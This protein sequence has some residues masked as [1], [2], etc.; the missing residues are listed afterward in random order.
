MA[1]PVLV[2]EDD[3]DIRQ[4]LLASLEQ[5]GFRV[6]SA[7][8]GEEAIR[9]AT[10]TRPAAVILDVALPKVSGAEVAASIRDL[11]PDGVP[12]LVISA[13]DRIEDVRTRIRAERYLAKPFD[14]DELVSAV[15]MLTEPPLVGG[16][17]PATAPTR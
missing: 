5:E 1:G 6:L 16:E 11:Y 14:L 2:V 10:A 9:I 7:A 15:R 12:L 13:T 8:D 17:E 3:K 4:L